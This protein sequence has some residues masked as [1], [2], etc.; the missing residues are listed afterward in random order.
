MPESC[1]VEGCSF[2]QSSDQQFPCEFQRAPVG[3]VRKKSSRKRYEPLAYP[4]AGNADEVAEESLVYDYLSRGGDIEPFLINEPLRRLIDKEDQAARKEKTQR[5][6]TLVMA[7]LTEEEAA[8]VYLRF[9]YRM[10]WSEISDLLG[11]SKRT[12]YNRWK[13]IRT[14]GYTIVEEALKGEDI[15]A[16]F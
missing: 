1:P 3:C 16:P 15:D 4:V 6:L 12:V 14:L 10:T 13:H 11:L 5:L 2:P 7:A 9:Q 8:I